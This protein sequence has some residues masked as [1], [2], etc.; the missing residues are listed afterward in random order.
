MASSHCISPPW[1]WCSG[2]APPACQSCCHHKTWVPE[3]SPLS[4]CLASFYSASLPSKVTSSG[5]SPKTSPIES[6]IPPCHTTLSSPAR[7]FVSCKSS[8]F[9]TTPWP[10][11]NTSPCLEFKH[12]LHL[13][14][15]PQHCNRSTASANKHRSNQEKWAHCGGPTSVCDVET[16]V[17]HLG[18]HRTGPCWEPVRWE[19]SG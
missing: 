17:R 3:G 15:S 11:T 19:P 7:V 6:S 4:G 2:S 14:S 16:H 18:G 1:P 9:P 10:P 13:P 8:V 5:R 12:R